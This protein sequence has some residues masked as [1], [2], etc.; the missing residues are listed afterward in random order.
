MPLATFDV[1]SLAGLRAF[2][3]ATGA[4]E[5]AP[6]E[7]PLELIVVDTKNEGWTATEIAPN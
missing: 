5:P 4:L 6:G 1:T 3:V 7:Q 2:T